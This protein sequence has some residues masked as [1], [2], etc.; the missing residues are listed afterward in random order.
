MEASELAIGAS[1]LLLIVASGIVVDLFTLW[2]A[3]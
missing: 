3:L 2:I 1:E